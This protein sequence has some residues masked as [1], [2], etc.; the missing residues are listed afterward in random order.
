MVKKLLKWIGILLAGLVALFFIGLVSLYF[1][2]MDK[3]NKVYEIPPSGI[4]VTS[5]PE[6]IARGKHLVT[7]LG[8]CALCHQEDFSGMYDDQGYLAAKLTTPNLTSGNGGVGSYYTDEDWVRA[9]RHGVKPNGKGGIGMF[10]QS[11]YHF[12]DEDVADMVAYIKS[13][14]PVDKEHPQTWLGPMVWFFLLQAPDLIPAQVI[15]HDSPRLEPQPGATAEYG[16]YLTR[17][18]I[19]CHGPELAGRNEPGTGPNLTPGGELGTWSEADFIRTLRTGTTPSE[20]LLDPEMMPW[21]TL[22]LMTDDELKAIWLYLQS[23]P[24]IE[25]TP[26]PTQAASSSSD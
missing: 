4:T 8:Q 15:D 16:E 7:V 21:E 5:Y 1:I 3:L 14:P 24:A 12:N 11:Y 6:S 18:C 2:T 23:I 22:G 19:T 13:I 17:F 25:T 10:A 9:I 20:R 26:F